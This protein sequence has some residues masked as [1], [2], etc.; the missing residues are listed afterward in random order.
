[1]CKAP[2]ISQQIQEEATADCRTKGIKQSVTDAA[3]VA[4]G[5]GVVGVPTVYVPIDP[6]PQHLATVEVGLVA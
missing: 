1:M 5:K 2:Y 6:P 4:F 3:F